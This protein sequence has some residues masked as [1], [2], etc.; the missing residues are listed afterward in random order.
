M[1][2]WKLTLSVA[3]GILIAGL[4]AVGVVGVLDYMRAQRLREAYLRS[5]GST[6]DGDNP[7]ARAKK[8]VGSDPDKIPVA[9]ATYCT[10]TAWQGAA[11]ERKEQLWAQCLKETSRHLAEEMK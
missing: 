9:A 11:P 7:F 8:A 5:Q 10:E 3:A 4:I 6:I 1:N 2:Y